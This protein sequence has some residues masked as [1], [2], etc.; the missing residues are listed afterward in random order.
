M[1]L[2]LFT[3][4]GLQHTAPIS[5][6]GSTHG[7]VNRGYPNKYYGNYG[8]TFTSAM[9]Y[10]SSG[11]DSR[12]NAQGLLPVD[13]KYK[14]KS[15]GNSGYYGYRTETDFGL[16]EM[17]RGPRGKGPKYPKTYSPITLAVKGQNLHSSE[18]VSQEKDEALEIPDRD[19]YN[20]TDFP[21]EYADAKFFI[22]KSYSEDDVHKSIKYNVW[23]STPTGNKKLDAAYQEAQQ[24]PGGCPVFLFFSVS[25]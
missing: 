17:N 24:K 2:C 4:Q 21:E 1:Y 18:T 15:R 16:N 9:G 20:R 25:H 23:A 8:D 7:Y 19:Q 22:I 5:G 11:Y 14:S 10:G 6:I 13:S 12:I 3:V